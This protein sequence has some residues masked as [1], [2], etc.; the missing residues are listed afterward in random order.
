VVDDALE[1]APLAVGA[2]RKPELT[3][4]GICSVSEGRREGAQVT[5]NTCFHSRVNTTL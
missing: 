1:R 5:F 2:G 3:E 4:G